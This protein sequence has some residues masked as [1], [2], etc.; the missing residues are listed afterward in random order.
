MKKIFTLLASVAFMAISS[1]AAEVT[2]NG[3][4]YSNEEYSLLE[5]EAIVLN[6]TADLPAAMVIEDEVEIEGVKHKVV[7]IA[8]RLFSNNTSKRGTITSVKLPAGLKSIGNYAFEDCSN[9]ETVTGI[10]TS[11]LENMGN[12]VFNGTK[13]ISNLT[14]EGVYLFGGWAIAHVG[15]VP[16]TLVIPNATVGICEGFLREGSPNGTY[17]KV[18]TLVLNEGLK[19]IEYRA[20]DSNYNLTEVNIPASL[21]YLHD[22]A[23]YNCGAL[24]AY[25]VAEENSTYCSDNG[26]LF[27]KTSKDLAKYPEGKPDESYAT[28]EYCN[29]ILSSAFYGVIHLKSLV[30]SEGVTHIF[31]HAIRAMGNLETIDLP[32]TIVALGAASF[33][34]CRNLKTIICRATEVPS[35]DGYGMDASTYDNT[36]VYVPGESLEAYKAHSGWGKFNNGGARDNIKT[37]DQLTGVDNIASEDAVEV[38]RYD[39]LGRQLA[40]PVKGVNIIKMSNGTTKKVIVK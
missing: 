2:I 4:V 24:E 8:D 32:S 27:M 11:N 35:F 7:K 10:P 16:E 12:R 28:P 17:Y 29:D 18:K 19:S 13:W 25:N 31:S 26:V 3:I 30:V 6:Y 40:Q 23:F 9:L 33:F 38:A 22:E 37:L 15:E 14:G 39:M 20:F 21:E 36:I 1:N 34:N 5:N